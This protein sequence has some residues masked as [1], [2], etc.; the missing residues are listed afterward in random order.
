MMKRFAIA[1]ALLAGCAPQAALHGT[2]L[3]PARRAAAFDLTDQNGHAFS[4]ASVRGSAVALYFG[5]THCKDVCPQTLALLGKARALAGLSPAQLRIVMITVDPARDNAP[6][7]RRFFGKAGVQA[8]GL[9]GPPVL[10][11]STYASYGVGVQPRNGDIAHTSSIFLIDA[12][13]RLRE[14]LDPDTAAKDVAHDMR[15]VVD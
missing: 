11:R 7:F 5:F 8:I 2:V 9:T 13:G 12:A 3:Q 15:A 1:V 14:L 10:L 6:A 4:L